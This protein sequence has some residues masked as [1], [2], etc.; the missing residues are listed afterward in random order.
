M[1]GFMTH[2]DAPPELVFD[3]TFTSAPEDGGAIIRFIASPGDRGGRDD[4]A[5]GPEDDDGGE[6]DDGRRSLKDG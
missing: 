5:H 6:G 2:I 1:S 4:L 3:E